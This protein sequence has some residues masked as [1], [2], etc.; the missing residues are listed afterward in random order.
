LTVV[1]K[2]R[3]IM[4]GRLAALALGIAI[5]VS[6]ASSADAQT[7]PTRQTGNS[8]SMQG[9]HT[10]DIRRRSTHGEFQREFDARR[11]TTDPSSAAALHE[12]ALAIADCIARRS[13]D[14]A[15]S[16]LGGGLAGDPDY[17]R[18]SGALTGRMQS[19]ARSE[20]SATAIAISGALAEQLLVAKPPNVQDRAP[21]VNE[22]VAHRFFGELTGAVTFDNIAGCLA[23][24]SPG[25]AYK[26][27]QAPV[28]SEEETAA[29]QEVYKRTPECG[30]SAPPQAIPQLY[31]R[32]ALATA[33][34]KWTNPS[35]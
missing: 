26:V 29:L 13:G 2:E 1:V 23:V 10:P 9:V 18:I 30:M 24:Y 35:A 3:K 32:G 7:G 8:G 25:L 22:D 14:R 15:S 28:A 33:L 11:L 5:T 16:Y 31:Q 6:L 4:P 21:A 17:E 12:G 20:A 19:C 27:L 34:Y